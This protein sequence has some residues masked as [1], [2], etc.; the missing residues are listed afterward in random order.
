MTTTNDT[1]TSSIFRKTSFMQSELV[2]QSPRQIKTTQHHYCRWYLHHH[3]S[4]V[5][6]TRCSQLPTAHFS[7]IDYHCAFVV[8]PINVQLTNRD[9]SCVSF[10]SRCRRRQQLVSKQKRSPTRLLAVCRRPSNH[11]SIR[12]LIHSTIKWN[13]LTHIRAFCVFW[14]QTNEMCKGI[15]EKYT[16]KQQWR[17]IK[18]AVFMIKTRGHIEWVAFGGL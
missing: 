13:S 15:A 18:F 7:H 17:I 2:S 10:S 1:I 11:P 6:P 8:L 4:G 5:G 3:T 9:D 16:N 12:R 14:K